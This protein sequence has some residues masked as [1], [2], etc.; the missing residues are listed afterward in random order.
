LWKLEKKLRELARRERRR[1]A[2]VAAMPP[3]ERARYEQRRRAMRPR[4]PAER[5]CERQDRE[6][7]ELL[8]MPRANAPTTPEGEWLRAEMAKLDEEG[9]RLAAWLAEHGDD[10]EQ[11]KGRDDDR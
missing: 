7:A 1:L 8:S 3:D 6:A 9:A 10:T 4:S 2:R 5:A 11:T